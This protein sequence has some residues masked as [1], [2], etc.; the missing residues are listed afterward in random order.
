MQNNVQLVATVTANGG[1]IENTGRGYF[2]IAPVGF[3]WVGNGN[4][5]RFLIQSV[6]S[7]VKIA[8]KGTIKIL[9]A[10]NRS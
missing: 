1:R 9:L 4:T 7:A 2:A 10:H 8:N 5:N 3:V 6:K